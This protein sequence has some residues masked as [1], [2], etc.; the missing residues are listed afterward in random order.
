MPREHFPGRFGLPGCRVARIQLSKLVV[1]RRKERQHAE[2]R[3]KL[4]DVHRVRL[5][6]RQGDRGQREIHLFQ[7]LFWCGV[8]IALV[9]VEG[10]GLTF[11]LGALEFEL[12]VEDA[13]S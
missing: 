12:L 8:Q 6:L 4:G 2:K 5:I 1:G 10:T 9:P 11:G 7:K 13:V 3:E